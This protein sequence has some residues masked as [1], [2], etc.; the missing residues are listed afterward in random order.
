MRPVGRGEF[1]E[2]IDGAEV[3]PHKTT[4]FYPKL[5]SGLVLWQL[6]EVSSPAAD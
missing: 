4:Y 1:Q 5:W 3:F 6:E 2:V